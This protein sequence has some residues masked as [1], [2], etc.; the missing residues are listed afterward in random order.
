MACRHHRLDIAVPGAPA[1]PA[2]FPH[3]KGRQIVAHFDGGDVT[4]DAGILLLRQL[5][6]EMG[7]TRGR[8]GCS[9]EWLYDN[10]YCARDEMENLYLRLAG[11]LV[12][13]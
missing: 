7:L 8:R 10:R 3:C 1:C 11:K 4:V 2:T 6:R 9:A 13:G 12:P 5:D